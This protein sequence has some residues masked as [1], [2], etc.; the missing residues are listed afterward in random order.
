MNE[1]IL[2]VK[3]LAKYLKMDEH[4]VYRL[5]RKGVLPGVKIGGEWRFKKDLIDRWIEEKSLD[6]KKTKNYE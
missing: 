3:E 1:E 4:T 2:T 6:K 5:A